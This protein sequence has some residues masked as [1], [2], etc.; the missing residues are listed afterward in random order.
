LI[1]AICEITASSDADHVVRALSFVMESHKLNVSLVKHFITYEVRTA[2]NESTLFRANSNVARLTTHYNK[3]VGLGYLWQTLALSIHELNDIGAG[4]GEKT[5]RYETR[6]QGMMSIMATTSLEA[7]PHKSED[8]TEVNVNQL[9]L[10][11]VAQKIFNAI[12]KSVDYI[13]VS[14]REVYSFMHN[15]LKS[16]FP[17]HAKKKYWQLSC[18]VDLF[19]LL[20]L[21][22]TFMD[23]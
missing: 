2:D 9:T 1:T 10:M 17:D 5:V 18:L 13:P 20:Y 11:L 19:V 23:F 14:M 12:I 7:D 22:L 3:L 21:P 4:E 6:S 16:K 15:E 8:I